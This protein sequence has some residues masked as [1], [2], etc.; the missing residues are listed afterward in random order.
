[1]ANGAIGLDIGHSAVKISIG[2]RFMFPTAVM[3]AVDLSVDANSANSDTVTTAKGRFFVG[4]TAMIHSGGRVLDGLKDDW[5]KGDEYHALLHAGYQKA[6]QRLGS[7]DRDDNILVMGLPSRL[8]ASQKGSLKAAAADELHLPKSRL[9]V[10]PQPL[11]AF[12]RMVFD[13]RGIPTN[14]GTNGERWY[15]IDIGYYTTDFGCVDHGV[16]AARGQASTAGTHVA[17]QNMK[18]MIESEFSLETSI[19]DAEKMLRTGTMRD[20]GEVIDVSGYVQ[21][22]VQPVAMDIIDKAVQVFGASQ[23]RS[24]HGIL[25]AGGGASLLGDALKT[26]WRHARQDA[27]PR[28]AVA[29]GLRRFGLAKQLSAA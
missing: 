14:S 25:V 8:H 24:A 20:H 19:R 6:I 27:E 23:I 9:F 2:E 29:E 10:L 7:G 4:E 12:Y 17:A 5:V 3:P 11:A 15:I 22:A 26:S 28:F 13:D 18:H 16:W 21:R 1:M